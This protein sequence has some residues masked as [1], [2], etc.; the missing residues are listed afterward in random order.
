[1]RR[2]PGGA[3]VE[4]TTTGRPSMTITDP[5]TITTALDAALIDLI[6]LGMLA[7]QAHWNVEGPTFRPL[8]V[9]LDELADLARNAGDDVAERAITLGHH[10]DGRAA[11]VA[12]AST[13]PNL[14]SGA[15]RDQ[16]VITT[17]GSIL[18]ATVR[19]LHTTIDR[20]CGDPVTQDLLTTIVA[21]LEK[22]A[23]MIRAH[24]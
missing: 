2:K 14:T 15:I 3:K 11:T 10:P 7:K 13:L 24:R 19:Q 21:A 6:N 23:W 22:Q 12:A 5:E 17:F 8:H 9:L 16:E 18:S 4:E 1:M 20:T